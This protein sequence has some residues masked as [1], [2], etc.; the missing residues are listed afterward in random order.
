MCRAQLSRIAFS[1]RAKTATDGAFYRREDCV[2]R[3]S[4]EPILARFRVAF[5][6][7]PTTAMS[8]EPSS[9]VMASDPETYAIVGAAM[10]VHTALGCGFLE[11]VYARALMAEFTTRAV[12]FTREARFSIEYKGKPLGLTFRPD[13]V[14]FNTVIV[15]TKALKQLTAI[16]LAQTL[17]YLKASGYKRALLLNFGTKSLEYR[18]F[19]M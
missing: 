16:D 9:I 4:H 10:A 2:R 3:A 13:F 1:V 6:V 7:H 12:P 5:G 14:C 18:R 19:V 15:E 8:T 17:N 11:K